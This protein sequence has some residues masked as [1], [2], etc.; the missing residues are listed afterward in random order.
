MTNLLR[1]TPGESYKGET[2]T[3]DTDPYCV[4]ETVESWARQVVWWQGQ[5]VTLLLKTESGYVGIVEG[6]GEVVTLPLSVW[7]DDSSSTRRVCY[8]GETVTVE[9]LSADNR[10]GWNAG[11]QSVDS[12]SGDAVLR[13]NIDQYPAGVLV[14][15]APQSSDHRFSEPTH[16]LYA[17]DGLI[18]VVESGLIVTTAPYA[19]SQV[20]TLYLV[21][22]QGVVSYIV[23]DWVYTSA[24][25]SF[26]AV[27]MDASL[28]LAGDYVDA[29]SIGDASSLGYLAA[30]VGARTSL[31]NRT[32]LGLLSISV[33]ARLDGQV[34][35]GTTYV[36]RGL[37]ASVGANASLANITEKEP[38]KRSSA[39]LRA[40]VGARLGSAFI[41]SGGG[42]ASLAGYMPEFIGFGWSE[43]IT[44]GTE[45]APAV[46]G[47]YMPLI[48][49]GSSEVVPPS[50]TVGGGLMHMRG[51]GY[52]VVGGLA[53]AAGDMPLTGYGASYQQGWNDS[54]AHLYMLMIGAGVSENLGISPDDIEN[55]GALSASVGARSSMGNRSAIGVL[56]ASA[57]VGANLNLYDGTNYP[58]MGL[59]ASAGARVS[60]GFY[61]VEPLKAS[62][63]SLS[64]SA[65]ARLGSAFIQTGGGYASAAG[66]MGPMFGYGQSVS[67]HEPGVEWGEARLTDG[68]MPE[69]FGYGSAP[70][71][72]N[73]L[74]VL[75]DGALMS[76]SMQTGIVAFAEIDETLSLGARIDITVA[77]D[78][79]WFE[80]LDLGE[81]YTLSALIEAMIEEGIRFEDDQALLSGSYHELQYAFV[82]ES[83]AATIYTDM[84][85]DAFAHTHFDT[86]GMRKDGLYL[87]GQP[88][89]EPLHAML[90]MGETD[91]GINQVKRGGDVFVGIGTDGMTYVRVLADG[92][93]RMYQATQSNQVHRAKLAKG[94]S[95]RRWRLQLEI[96]DATDANIDMIEFVPGLTTR[97]WR[98]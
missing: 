94:V 7:T 32:S 83:G 10:Q 73:N 98:R 36:L 79:D 80:F 86:F 25:E 64:A 19:P 35:D 34:Y 29:P 15:I 28:Y 41:Q 21:R 58:L 5:R 89:E 46:G 49:K 31:G 62:A 95:G 13:W 63:A 27:H 42:Y 66:V 47:G 50:I 60:A 9:V 4:A 2:I 24:V 12:V 33:G 1:K 87:M 48:G 84:S 70:L 22:T 93:E 40:S 30:S 17:A 56:R 3:Y 45:P 81:D 88:E 85:F 91:L 52:A 43:D 68:M 71:T 54:Q 39:S 72:S 18:N 23:G 76:D 90:S 6:T 44:T 26:G 14:G 97:R 82:T 74:Y 20:Q 11:G 75:N 65:G 78:A 77:L 59:R 8:A 51:S 96:M 16:G 38:L 55:L 37:S 53:D 92:D 69:W 67:G 61:E 57:G